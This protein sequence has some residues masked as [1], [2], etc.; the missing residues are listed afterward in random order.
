MVCTSFFV[1]RGQVSGSPS[2][3]ICRAHIAAASAPHFQQLNKLLS[4]L[5]S[6]AVRSYKSIAAAI[7]GSMGGSD[8]HSLLHH[9]GSGEFIC[10]HPL[11]PILLCPLRESGNVTTARTDTLTSPSAGA[12]P[13]AVQ[14][15]LTTATM[16]QQ[17]Y[18]RTGGCASAS[19]F[20]Q[21]IGGVTRSG[22]SCS[23]SDA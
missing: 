5:M 22:G 20:D 2:Q 19:S 1:S 9:R 16:C 7:A 13:D 17:M 23:E 4:I 10:C 3:L 8:R 18:S 21:R 14:R 12:Q 6:T 11:V 15:Q